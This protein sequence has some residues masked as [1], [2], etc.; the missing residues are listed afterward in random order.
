MTLPSSIT[1]TAGRVTLEPTS[2]ASLSTVRTSSTDAFSCLPPQRT[3]AYTENSPSVVRARREIRGLVRHR[4]ELA[5]LRHTARTQACSR[6]PSDAPT[7]KNIRRYGR[8]SRRWLSRP[9]AAG[10]GLA[11]AGLPGRSRAGIGHHGAVGL[12]VIGRAGVAREGVASGLR[13]A[14]GLAPPPP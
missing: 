14:D 13:L 6:R 8:S 11:R 12:S 10:T 5:R 7:T 3:I 4:C 9:C 1:S 2:P